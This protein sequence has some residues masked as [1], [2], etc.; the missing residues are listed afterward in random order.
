MGKYEDAD[1]KRID[2]LIVE[3]IKRHDAWNGREPRNEIMYCAVFKWKSR[4]GF[5]IDA[6]LVAFVAPN[7]VKIGDFHWSRWN[8]HLATKGIGKKGH[9]SSARR[10]SF[11]VG[12][13]EKC[14]TAQGQ[15]VP[16]LLAKE[17]DVTLR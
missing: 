3:V 10:F 8:I 1:G 4:R 7:N 2:I 5:P 15:L 16:M 14:H 12:E 13:N 6:A 17:K 11:L 9:L